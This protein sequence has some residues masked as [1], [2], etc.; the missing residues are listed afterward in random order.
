MIFLNFQVEWRAR[1]ESE[2]LRGR[3]REKETQKRSV[4]LKKRC[5]ND[6]RSE[7][8]PK[9]PNPYQLKNLDDE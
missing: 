6:F 1:T 4:M 9:M 3:K 5:K 8:L 7:M 2:L